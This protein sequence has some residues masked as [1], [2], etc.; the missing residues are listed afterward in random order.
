MVYAPACHSTH[1]E[2]TLLKPNE[3]VLP[4]LQAMRLPRVNPARSFRHTANAVRQ[5]EIW[6]A[7][8]DMHARPPVSTTPVL[9]QLGKFI[10]SLA[11]PKTIPPPTSAISRNAYRASPDPQWGSFWHA[12]SQRPPHAQ[13]TRVYSAWIQLTRSSRLTVSS[14]AGWSVDMCPLIIP[15]TWSSLS[16]RATNPHSHRISFTLAPPTLAAC[17]A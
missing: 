3:S 16:P 12:I 2:S 10:R 11:T 7:S 15:T 14:R 17:P 9:A 1:D 8:A 4:T 13:P 5:A 6:L